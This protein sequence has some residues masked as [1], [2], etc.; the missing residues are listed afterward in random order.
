VRVPGQGGGGPCSGRA[1]LW[2]CE[3]MCRVGS[4]SQPCSEHLPSWPRAARR[5]VGVRLG[6]GEA[7]ADILASSNQMAEGVATAGVV[8]TLA[9]RFRVS[10]PVLTAV[11]QARAPCAPHAGRGARR[12]APSPPAG[13]GVSVQPWKGDECWAS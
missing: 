13:G 7:L 9:R 12:C 3:G 10:L 4:F 11:A 5:S 8:V 6:R 2:C 1:S